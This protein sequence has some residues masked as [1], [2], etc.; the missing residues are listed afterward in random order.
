MLS[1]S[2][3]S[4]SVILILVAFVERVIGD[5]ETCTKLSNRSRNGV[6]SFRCTGDYCV[7]FGVGCD[8]EDSGFTPQGF[9]RLTIRRLLR[10]LAHSV[11]QT[12]GY[13]NGVLSGQSSRHCTGLPTSFQLMLSFRQSRRDCPAIGSTTT[14]YPSANVFLTYQRFLSCRVGRTRHWQ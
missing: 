5:V 10:F 9:A 2:L 14:S 1:I 6:K 13:R 12:G 4:V 8:G 3:S 7:I 11:E